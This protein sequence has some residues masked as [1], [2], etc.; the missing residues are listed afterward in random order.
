[1]PASLSDL[2]GRT[3]LRANRSQ[4]VVP[5][6]DSYSIHSSSHLVR[7]DIFFL[8]SLW[9]IDQINLSRYSL[10]GALLGV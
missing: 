7:L 8:R 2:L 1:M 6:L 10:S 3:R 4:V 5:S 9:S